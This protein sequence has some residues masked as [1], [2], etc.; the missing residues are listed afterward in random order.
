MTVKTIGLILFIASAILLI[1]SLIADPIGIGSYPGMNWAQ[2]T[3]TGVGLV[4]CLVG[5]WL[6]LRKPKR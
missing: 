2:L 3:G 5:I 6:F 1:L 4:V